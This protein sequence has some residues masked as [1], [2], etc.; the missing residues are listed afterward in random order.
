MPPIV[1]GCSQEE[2]QFQMQIVDNG[3][4]MAK[5]SVISSKFRR[6][7]EIRCKPKDAIHEAKSSIINRSRMN[8]MTRLRNRAALSIGLVSMLMLASIGFGEAN[9]SVG[10][11][12][13]PNGEP[14]VVVPRQDYSGDVE[15]DLKQKSYAIEN[16]I[17]IEAE[18]SRCF[19]NTIVENPKEYEPTFVVFKGTRETRISALAT[20][21]E[22]SRTGLR[23]DQDVYIFVHG[24]TQSFPETD[25]LR[26]AATLFIENGHTVHDNAIIMDWGPAAKEGFSKAAAMVSAMGSYLSNFIQKLLQMGVHWHRIHLICHSLGGHVCGFAGK[27]IR[28]PI[29]RITAID[30]AGPCFGKVASNGPQDRL[31]YD[32]AYEVDVYHYDDDFL[33]IGDQHFSIR[34][35]CQRRQQSAWLQGQH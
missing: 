9:L 24:F 26:N 1:I 21:D 8:I 32:D 28:P 29:G 7:N 12:G 18:K 4:C 31:S 23:T 14:N 6:F 11:F 3:G 5:S 30:P 33:G 15:R 20:L 2:K 35:V 13:K 17:F 22:I 16:N 10:L 34:R 19:A 27:K 25:W